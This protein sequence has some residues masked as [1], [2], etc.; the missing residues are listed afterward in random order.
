MM[1]SLRARFLV[2]ALLANAALLAL[3]ALLVFLAVRAQLEREYDLSLATQVRALTSLIEQDGAHLD[4]EYTAEQLPDYARAERPDY[5]CF[6][7][8]GG[9]V[10]YRSPSLKAEDLAHPDGS[11]GSTPVLR[12][13]TLP[14]GRPG[15]SATLVFMPRHEVA[16]EVEPPPSAVRATVTVTVARD[17]LALHEALRWLATVLVA[18]GGAALVIAA[19]V[20]LWLSRH[21]MK[22]VDRLAGRIAALEVADLA[23]LVDDGQVPEELR[24]VTR[25]LDDLLGRLAAAFARER[26]FTADVAHELRTP[27]AG[28]RTSV[29]VALTR[30]RDPA[31]YRSVLGTCLS[32]CTGMQTLVDHLLSFARLEA[33]K[34][35][36]AVSTIDLTALL[37][38]CWGQ[39][40]GIAE[41]RRLRVAWEVPAGVLVEGDRDHLRVVVM[42]LVDN[43]VSYCDAGGE[44]AVAVA[45]SQDRVQLRIATTGCTLTAE[46]ASRVFDR[47]W[48]ADASRAAAGSHAGLG[49]SLCRTIITLMR[50]TI[51]VTV[52]DGRFIVRLG[53]VVPP[54]PPADSLP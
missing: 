22:P 8:A 39:Y 10:L 15:R 9:G 16:D 34:Q 38:D 28:L 11:A 30:E 51:D 3:S 35:E 53:M 7:S 54:A 27:L 23:S 14:D 4:L 24:P 5:F 33:G 1:R 52:A 37:S 36:L 18:I 49:L 47:F 50:G 13:L 43:A 25:R 42:N 40:A 20:L 31:A 48:R 41:A 6:W 2:G 26:S 17:V 12:D 21:V 44:L 32:I 46:Q 19:A 45:P 29:E